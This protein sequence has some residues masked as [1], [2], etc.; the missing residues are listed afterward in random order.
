[1]AAGGLRP[2]PLAV[3]GAVLLVLLA[4]SLL[5]VDRLGR[6]VRD[7]G[8]ENRRMASELLLA[9]AEMD[10][11]S[12]MN[13]L[14]LGLESREELERRVDSL[15]ARLLADSMEEGYGGYYL[16]VDT[17]QNR[18]H[19][20]LGDGEGG[21]YLVRS[22]Y[23]GTG[24]GWTFNARGQAWDF[25]TPRG[26]HY[27]LETGENPY[28]YRP[29]WYWEEQNLT[30]P[31]PDEVVL[32]PD[33]LSWEEQITYY[34]DSLTAS[35]R[36]WVQAVPG[37]L[38]SYKIDLGGGLLIHYGVGRGRN[39]SHGCIRLGSTDLEALYRTLPVGAPVI[40]Y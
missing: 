37:A 16:V 31:D 35:E 18:F 29:D 1:M 34:H 36:I 32:I 19:L 15:E 30:P 22:G 40:V 5:T 33:T 20:R 14:L 17:Y 7:I 4:I 24:K 6:R 23:C 2:S 38:G 3:S 26:V 13:E 39:V 10:T 9:R 21:S 11:L 12:G 27:V 8:E 28:W 25:S